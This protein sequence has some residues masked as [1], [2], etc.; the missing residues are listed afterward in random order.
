[1]DA[2]QRT[3]IKAGRKDLAQKYYRRVA[4][5]IVP[6]EQE[7]EKM[8]KEFIEY[9]DNVIKMGQKAK[10]LLKAKSDKFELD[11]NYFANYC[12]TIDDQDFYQYFFK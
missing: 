5:L 11:I 6:S 4:K 10:R 8:R 12:A 3:L 2:I 7:E 1:M 9:I